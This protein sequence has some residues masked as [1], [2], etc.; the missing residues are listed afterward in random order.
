[1]AMTLALLVTNAMVLGRTKSRDGLVRAAIRNAY[2]GDVGLD[3]D[4][5]TKRLSQD[6]CQESDNEPTHEL[7]T[8][9]MIC[10]C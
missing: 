5:G 7:M 3:K 4:G 9:S 8:Y 10:N 1:M 6:Q 2:G